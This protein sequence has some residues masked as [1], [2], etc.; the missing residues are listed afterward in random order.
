MLAHI[1]ASHGGIVGGIFAGF[2]QEG[3]VDDGTGLMGG[4][5]ICQDRA[6][7]G[8]E[9]GTKCISPRR[10]AGNRLIS[11]QNARS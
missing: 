1:H 2:A 10:M 3:N 4:T 9:I 11:K 7:L 6:R 5:S 8:D